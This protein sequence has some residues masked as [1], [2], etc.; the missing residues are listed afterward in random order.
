MYV[1]YV[2]VKVGF[3]ISNNDEHEFSS[4]RKWISCC[5]DIMNHAD[6][7]LKHE[8]YLQ[9]MYSCSKNIRGVSFFYVP[10]ISGMSRKSIS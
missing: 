10:K 6:C 8:V 7:I 1:F 9:K 5:N 4:I 3:I 2:S